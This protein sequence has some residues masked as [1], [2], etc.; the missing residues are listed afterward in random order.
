MSVTPLIIQGVGIFMAYWNSYLWPSLTVTGNKNLQ[1]LTQVI[2]LLSIQ[3]RGEYGITIAAALVSLIPPLII[4]GI[5][6]KKIVEGITL[7]GLK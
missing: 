3:N 5:L 4:F 2:N 6:Q 7:S 1:Q